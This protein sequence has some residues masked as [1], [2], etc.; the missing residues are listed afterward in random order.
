MHAK[1]VYEL[2]I[3]L[4]LPS[5]LALAGVAWYLFYEADERHMLDWLK[6]SSRPPV[7]NLA[8]STRDFSAEPKLA[9][10]AEPERKVAAARHHAPPAK[11]K[12]TFEPPA[13]PPALAGFLEG[14][15][16]R[17]AQEAV[18]GSPERLRRL[19]TLIAERE[20]VIQSGGM[21]PPCTA[22][23]LLSQL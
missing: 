15:M 1:E 4:G 5:I 13:R 23:E 17:Q 11:D 10:R 3:L 16:R 20:A 9:P 21:P 12:P 22:Q 18:A 8:H 19:E 2:L 7:E 14:Q 6:P